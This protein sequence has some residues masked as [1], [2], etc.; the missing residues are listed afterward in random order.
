LPNNVLV[1]YAYDSASRLTGITYKQNGTTVI[2][3]LTYEY[4]K[5]GNRTKIGGSWARTG[6]PEPV[7]STSYDANNRQ[8]TFGNKTLAY[9]DNGNLQSITDS[10]GTTLYS[11]NA[12]NQL[13]GISG[14]SVNASFVYDGVGRREK[15]T[16]NG[17]LTEFLYD[18]V[19]PVQEISAATVLANVLTGLRMDEFFSRTDVVAGTTSHFV[20]DALGSALGLA[21]DAGAVQTEY[22]FESFGKTSAIGNSNSNA[23]Q[24]TGR[25]NDGTGIYYYRTRYYH[26]QLQRFIGEDPIGLGSGDINLYAYVFDNPVKS[27]D[28]LGLDNYMCTKPLHALG[29]VGEVVYGMSVPLLYHQFICVKNGQTTVCGGQDRE[30]G[31]YSNGKPSQDDINNGK[32]EK[33]QEKG[34]PISR[35]VK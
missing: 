31:P 25:E 10:N 18:E 5:A 27:T 6:M 2:G 23:F 33:G 20:P 1:E 15:K 12:K 17:S 34:S 22:T 16:I 35:Q 4:D 21:N 14:P 11:W 24:Y 30:G 13:V 29:K 9:D 26:P 19:N 3:D 32:C 8:L 28:P 7:T